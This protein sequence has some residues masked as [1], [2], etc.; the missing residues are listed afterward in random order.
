MLKQFLKA[1]ISENNQIHESNV[2]TPQGGVIS[3]MLANIVLDGLEDALGS[4][5]IVVRYA[6][7]FLVLGKTKDSLKVNART[8]IER[9]LSERGVKLNLEKSK[10]VEV[11]QGFD[12][13]G[14]HFREFKDSSRIKGKKQGIMLVLPAK[15]KVKQFRKEIKDIFMKNKTLPLYLIINKLNAYMRG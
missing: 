7:D 4:E 2:G 6:D 11:S 1:G 15:D 9:F 10:I 3:P 14:F 8:K 12:F 13:L 5:F